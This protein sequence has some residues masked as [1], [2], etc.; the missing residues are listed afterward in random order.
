MVCLISPV[1][2]AAW[3]SAKG[4]GQILFNTSYFE[5]TRSFDTGGRQQPFGYG[6]KFQKVEFNPYVEVGVTNRTSLLLNAFIPALRF[7]NQYGGFESSGTGD[8]EV[9]IRQRLTPVRMRTAL[10]FQTMFL[11]PTYSQDRNPAPG[12]HVWDVEP[13]VQVGRSHSL[14]KRTVF[15][16]VEAAW[17]YRS[18]A[19]ADQMR[20]D[21]TLGGD[22]A[23]RLML[24]AQAF[25]IKGLRN[26]TPLQFINNPNLQS[27]FDLYKAQISTVI[28]LTSRLRLQTGY[29]RAVKGRNTGA[30]QGVVISLWAAF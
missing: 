26:G 28:R 11:F 5:T 23:P 6:G 24:M 14:E 16:D 19:P 3:T 2:S 29:F 7:Q 20:F 15:W 13:R 18:G 12:N 25:G 10:S 8:V 30:G 9:G 22:V 27:D 21:A 4:H 1:Y 17:R